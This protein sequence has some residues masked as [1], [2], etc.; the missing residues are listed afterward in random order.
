MLWE[1][2]LCNWASLVPLVL[3]LAAVLAELKSSIY[4]AQC[5]VYC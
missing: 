1:V 2:Q 4:T 5:R 3:N